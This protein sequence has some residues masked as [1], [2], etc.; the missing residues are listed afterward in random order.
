M[1]GDFKFTCLRMEIK[2]LP[3]C[4]N[5]CRKCHTRW[6]IDLLSCLCFCGSC[7][8]PW[9]SHFSPTSP[10]ILTLSSL[11][12]SL[13][14]HSRRGGG[15]GWR[16]LWGRRTARWTDSYWGCSEKKTEQVLKHVCV[17]VCVCMRER[18]VMRSDQRDGKPSRLLTQT[19]QWE[20]NTRGG[21]RRGPRA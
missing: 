4:G 7:F 6:K 14:M 20:R 13:R 10:L 8:E 5:I 1:R 17:C 15:A 3:Q 9:E 21:E 12:L 18:R 2:T 19:H 11:Q 16:G